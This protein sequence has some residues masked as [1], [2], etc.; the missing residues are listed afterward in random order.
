VGA[1]RCVRASDVGAPHRRDRLF[2]LAVR[3]DVAPDTAE[4]GRA[5]RGTEHVEQERPGAPGHSDDAGLTLLPTPAARLGASGSVTRECAEARRARRPNGPN[6]DDA[7]ALLP[8]PAQRDGRRGK[9]WGNQPGR[10]LSET[11]H[12]ISDHSAGWGKYDQAIARWEEVLGQPAPLPTD[13]LTRTREPRLSP[14]FVEW[15]MGLPEGWVTD[16]AIGLTRAQQLSM[17]GD[18]VV[19]QQA[20]HAYGLLLADLAT[21]TGRSAA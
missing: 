10:P 1:W 11:I 9:G 4:L 13:L 5:T 8:T 18:G 2:L 3:A 7:I 16:P 19:P 14:K 6:L 12:R 21:T 15:V 20:R 17:L